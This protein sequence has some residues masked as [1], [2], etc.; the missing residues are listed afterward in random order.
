M[1]VDSGDAMAIPNGCGI[2]EGEMSV[3]IYFILFFILLVSFAV[4]QKD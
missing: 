4:F 2:F 3:S 1:G